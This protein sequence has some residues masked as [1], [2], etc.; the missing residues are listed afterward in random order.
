MDWVVVAQITQLLEDE[1][2][3]MAGKLM[4]EN[5]WVMKVILVQGFIQRYAAASD[6]DDIR[7]TRR[8]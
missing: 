5:L 7:D 2:L 4:D 3:M 6:C 8:G 1:K